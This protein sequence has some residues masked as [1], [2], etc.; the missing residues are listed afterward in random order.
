M[1]HDSLENM[2]RTDF[3]LIKHHGYTQYDLNHMVPFVRKVHVLLLMQHLQELEQAQKGAE[4][5]QGA[6]QQLFGGHSGATEA[7]EISSIMSVDDAQWTTVQS[8]ENITEE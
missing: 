5:G 3:A 1:A 4:S 8:N 6:G 7:E 2:L